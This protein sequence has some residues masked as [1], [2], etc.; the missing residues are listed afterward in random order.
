MR[1]KSRSHAIR[2]IRAPRFSTSVIAA[3]PSRQ[4]L[5]GTEFQEYPFQ[6]PP[7]VGRVFDDKNAPAGK[8][9]V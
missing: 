2:L 1:G 9:V 8:V 3:K 7:N 4:D 5:I 6:D